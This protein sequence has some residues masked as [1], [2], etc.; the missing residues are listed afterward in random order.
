MVNNTVIFL[1]LDGVVHPDDA[2][3]LGSDDKVYGEDL[4][5]F[6]GVLEKILS[7]YPTVKI[8]ISS[9]WRLILPL[10]DI[11][12]YFPESLRPRIIAVTSTLQWERYNAILEYVAKKSV[13][14]YVILDDAKCDFPDDLPE[15]I[16]C[17][18]KLGIHEDRVQEELIA[19]LNELTRFDVEAK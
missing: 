16:W 15:L 6:I 12:E 7:N 5:L 3:Y 11:I 2:G 4:F 19:R 1:D 17:H 14:R 13:K 18:S 10:K 9:T 8:V